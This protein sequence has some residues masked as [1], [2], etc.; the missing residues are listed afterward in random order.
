MILSSQA[1][2]PDKP[3]GWSNAPVLPLL[4]DAALLAALGH[5]GEAEGESTHGTSGRGTVCIGLA[6]QL[7][8]GYVGM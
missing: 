6:S 8:M 7:G 2:N 3:A 4:G 5:W 1:P